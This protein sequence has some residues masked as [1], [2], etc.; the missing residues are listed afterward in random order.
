MHPTIPC[1]RRSQI[2]PLRVRPV[3]LRRRDA[4]PAHL[5]IVRYRPPFQ[6]SPHNQPRALRL[7]RQM[8]R[9]QL[10]HRLRRGSRTAR[11]RPQ[12]RE[13]RQIHCVTPAGHTRLHRTV[14]FPEQRAQARTSNQDVEP[15]AEGSAGFR[16]RAV[17]LVGQQAAKRADRHPIRSDETP[18]RTGETPIRLNETPIR[19]SE[20]LIRSGESPIRAGGCPISETPVP[21]SSGWSTDSRDKTID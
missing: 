3:L 19:I 10:V 15:G 14:R 9:R 17:R 12:L 18:I 13:G 7:H 5:L 4:P 16:W 11:A 2:R 8:F 21:D 20:T 6:L 1:P